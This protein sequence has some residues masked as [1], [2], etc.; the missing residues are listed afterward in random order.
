MPTP[1][2]SVERPITKQLRVEIKKL[3]GCGYFKETFW[4]RVI[5]AN[6]EKICHSY[7]YESKAKCLK[8][9]RLLNIFIIDKT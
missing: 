9:A 6:G 2:P 8:S 4:F 7:N 3:A 1:N 5:G